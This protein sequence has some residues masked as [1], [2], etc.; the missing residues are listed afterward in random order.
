MQLH[1]TSLRDVRLVVPA[2]ALLS[3]AACDTRDPAPPSHGAA[4]P[5]APSAG[6]SVP[7]PAVPAVSHWIIDPENSSVAFSVKHVRS[8]VRGLFPQPAGTIT[9]DEHTPANSRITA[10]IDP[11]LVTTGVAERDTH[12]QSPDFFD[13]AA[14]PVITFTSTTVTRTSTTAYAVTGDLTILATTRPVTLA[15]TAPPAFE[16]A[17]G[18][19]RGIEATASIN[20]KD[21][22]IA[23]EFPGEGPGVVVGDTISLIINA[24]LVLQPD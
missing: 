22:G 21:F 16:H 24:E 18:I 2:I 14:H 8:T 23:W 10:T 9:L 4:A 13:V 6:P 1:G 19:R 11:R 20:R 7:V 17:G 5:S 12:L 3:L 15:V